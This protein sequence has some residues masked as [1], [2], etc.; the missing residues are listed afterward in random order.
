MGRAKKYLSYSQDTRVYVYVCAGAR[1]HAHMPI[2][3]VYYPLTLEAAF[4]Q[5]CY[6]ITSMQ[7]N[8]LYNVTQKHS[9]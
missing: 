7:V 2:S 5:K 4:F 3:K 8:M 1:A 9:E 6:K